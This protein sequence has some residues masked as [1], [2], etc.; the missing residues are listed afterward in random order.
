M[1]CWKRVFATTS[2]FS[3]QN[4][5]SLCPASFCTLRPNFP[6]ILGISQFSFFFFSIFYFHIPIPYHEKEIFF[7]VSSRKSCKSSK[8]HS[9]SAYLALCC[10]GV[11]LDYCHIEWFALETIRDH[12]VVFEIAPKCCISGSFV[13]N[14]GYSISSKGFLPQ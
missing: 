5:V 4:S 3:W 9:N 12:S 1:C 11:Y 7:G 14:E 10:W 6:V 13:N 2:V 8:N